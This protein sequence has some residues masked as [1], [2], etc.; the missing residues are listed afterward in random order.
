MQAGGMD[1]YNC[2]LGAQATRA[3]LPD[4]DS[5]AHIGRSKLDVCRSSF[6]ANVRET[7][8]ESAL[9][10]VALRLAQLFDL[11]A[12]YGDFIASA[13]EVGLAAR[14]ALR[15]SYVL[16]FNVSRKVWGQ[17]ETRVAELEVAT[18]RLEAVSGLGLIGA[19][20]RQV[21]LT[22]AAQLQPE[23]ADRTLRAI[24]L[25]E[26]L[27]HAQATASSA[28]FCAQLALAV[29]LQ[30]SRLLDTVRRLDLEEPDDAAAASTV[31]GVAG[32][33]ADAA[34]WTFGGAATGAASAAVGAGRRLLGMLVSRQ[35]R[36]SA[37]LGVTSASDPVD[38]GTRRE[39]AATSYGLS[40]AT[41]DAAA[42]AGCARV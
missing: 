11:G 42:N 2:R 1:Y 19:A 36:E 35:A 18:E 21:G 16:Q 23:A 14:R 34:T 38:R 22:T 30:T 26:V 9:A 32:A 25:R 10:D 7:E 31:A 27:A 20:A 17:L 33:A 40:G 24:D 29:E 5:N 6:T 41:L 37:A 12:A 8:W 13:V 39:P 28:D 3:D 15:F 4:R